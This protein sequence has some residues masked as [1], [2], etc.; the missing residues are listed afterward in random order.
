MPS[1]NK[2]NPEDQAGQYGSRKRQPRTD[3]SGRRLVAQGFRAPHRMLLHP[4]RIERPTTLSAAANC[5]MFG[6][7]TLLFMH[8]RSLVNTKRHVDARWF[9]RAAA[10]RMQIRKGRA[11]VETTAQAGG[12]LG[13]RNSG[14]GLVCR[15]SSS[16]T[17]WD[18]NT[19][20]SSPRWRTALAGFPLRA[21]RLGPR[22]WAPSTD[23]AKR[24]LSFYEP[25]LYRL[26]FEVKK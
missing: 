20:P 24:L 19:T 5:V 26:L 25:E 13:S 1:T 4:P 23:F 16:L 18:S 21:W 2:S 8:D 14:A 17:S 6:L 7:A 15:R 11:A 9:H 22:R 10:Q 12:Q 3:A